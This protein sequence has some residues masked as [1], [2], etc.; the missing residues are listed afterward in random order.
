MGFVHTS[1]TQLLQLLRICFLN[2]LI[3]VA[4]SAWHLWVP[5]DHREQ[6]GGFKQVQK[7]YKQLFPQGLAQSKQAKTLRS[8]FF[9]GRVLS[10][11]EIFWISQLLPWFRIL[12][13]LHLRDDSR[14]SVVFWV[15]EWACGRCPIVPS[16]GLLQRQD[17]SPQLTGCLWELIVPIIWWIP[18][19]DKGKEMSLKGICSKGSAKSC[20]RSFLW[21]SEEEVE[22]ELQLPAYLWWEKEVE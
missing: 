18:K 15:P 3:L 2:H 1:N 17:W 4:V 12:A 10:T 7:H 22:D 20:H 11:Y 9:H 6:I 5:Q 13:I 14:Q 16:S 8:H 21:I 19:G